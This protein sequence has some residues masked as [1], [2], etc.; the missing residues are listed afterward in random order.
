MM[1]LNLRIIAFRSWNTIPFNSPFRARNP[2]RSSDSDSP[3]NLGSVGQNLGPGAL[4]PEIKGQWLNWDF[5]WRP[6]WR[7]WIFW[8]VAWNFFKTKSL[9]KKHN[10]HSYTLQKVCEPK[11]STHGHERWWVSPGT[12]PPAHNHT[13]AMSENGRIS[14]MTLFTAV[15]LTWSAARA[16][17]WCS[18]LIHL[19]PNRSELINL[20]ST[21]FWLYCDL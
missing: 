15:C 2:E 1:L 14:C 12:H 3:Q 5:F 21:R 20:I 13:Y 17:V 18:H 11:I 7:N 9:S 8:L 16:E 19:I 6:R 10:L 4:H